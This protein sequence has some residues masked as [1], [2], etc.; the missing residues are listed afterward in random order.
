MHIVT[1]IVLTVSLLLVNFKT[2]AQNCETL[3]WDSVSW[4]AGSLT[5][6][7]PGT[8]ATLDF[9][10]TDTFGALLPAPP[11]PVSL[12]VNFAFYQNITSLLIS[13]DLVTLGTDRPVVIDMNLGTP[14]T[15]V[16]SVE[17]RLFDVDGEVGAFLR[18]ESYVVTGSLAGA[19]VAPNLSGT[20]SHVIAGNEVRGVSSTPASGPG[21]SDGDVLIG[22]P[23]AV[24]SIR[25]SYSV[26]NSPVI[27][28]GSQP[29]FGL[30]DISYCES[31]IDGKLHAVP[32]MAH[33]TLPIFFFCMIAVVG[34]TV[35]SKRA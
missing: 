14:G 30:S 22:F 5:N 18:E 9:T 4:A 29:G 31:S 20:S 6:T 35:R 21:A 1:N 28:P 34:Y 26:V 16:D 27:N 7:Y 25:I 19:P 10:V 33:P 3:Q 23:S 32:V 11:S 24:D 15:G 13:V 2:V 8:I 17:F 12:P